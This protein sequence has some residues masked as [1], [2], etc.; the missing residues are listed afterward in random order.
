[1]TIKKE[2]INASNLF[3]PLAFLITLLDLEAFFSSLPYPETRS[4]KAI[5]INENKAKEDEETVFTSV[6]VLLYSNPAHDRLAS[7]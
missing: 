3:H 4:N 2:R 5:I 1:M 6:Y 7:F